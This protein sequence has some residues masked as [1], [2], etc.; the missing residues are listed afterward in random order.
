MV[1]FFSGVV[2]TQAR[3]LETFYKSGVKNINNQLV[4]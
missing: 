1:L 2:Q 3:A 4:A